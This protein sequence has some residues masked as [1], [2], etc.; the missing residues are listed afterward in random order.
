MDST[1]K[2]YVGWKRRAK[3]AEARAEQAERERDA[4][5][6]R[7]HVM[8]GERDDAWKKRDEHRAAR[9]RTEADNAA[10]LDHITRACATDAYSDAV[11][12]LVHLLTTHHPGAAL[13]ARLRALE[14]VLRDI[15]R[16]AGDVS[17]GRMRTIIADALKETP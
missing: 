10:L 5:R 11:L 4:W 13:L 9:E 3:E 7:C 15:G 14:E 1:G 6:E 8:E 17:P 12:G 16:H 2:M